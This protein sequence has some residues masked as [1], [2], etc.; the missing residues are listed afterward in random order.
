MSLRVYVLRCSFQS[1]LHSRGGDPELQAG[2]LQ[3]CWCTTRPPGL[4]GA[5]SALSCREGQSRT[6][7]LT[8]GKPGLQGHR[9]CV[10]GRTEEPACCR[11]S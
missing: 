9:F 2:A 8:M 1:W 5:T 3:P 7:V 4:A 6:T 11:D 10:V